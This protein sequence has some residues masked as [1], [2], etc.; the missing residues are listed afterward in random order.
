[1]LIFGK[2]F[3]FSA[4]F[5]FLFYLLIF[6]ALLENSYSHLDPDMGWHLKA[7]RHIARS[8]E[9]SRENLYNYTFSGEWINHEWLVDWISF[10]VYD[11]L[12]YLALSILFALVIVCLLV[13]VNISTRRLAN[14]PIAIAIIQLLG[15][16]ASLP[17]FGIR[18]Q[19]FSVLFLFL[20]LNIINAFR[21]EQ[22]W[23]QL[24]WLLPLFLIWVN[25]HG[26]FFF[27]LAIFV[28]WLIV[29][30]LGKSLMG[31]KKLG[32]Y[33]QVRNLTN[34][35]LFVAIIF[36]ALTFLIT[37]INPYGL[38]LY[39]F[40]IDYKN[41]AYLNLID[42]W[43]PL[44]SFP[45]GYLKIIYLGFLSGAWILYIYEVLREKK[46]RIDWW[47]LSLFILFLVLSFKSKR[48][49][50]LAFIATFPYFIKILAGLFD[51][52]KI[53]SM[54][55]GKKI[56]YLLF[57]C[58]LL[59]IV[60]LSVSI[61]FNKNP[62]NEFCSSYPCGAVK[63]LQSNKQYDDYRIFNEYGWGGY[64]IWVYPERQLFIDGRLPQVSFAGKTFIEEYKEFFIKEADRDGKLSEHDIRLVL[65]RA[66]D[67]PL[68]IKKW[69]KI[70]FRITDEDL[71][72]EN[73]LRKYLNES[74]DWEIIYQDEVAVIYKK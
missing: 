62:F 10:E 47:Q 6:V 63:F 59:S 37:L 49:F 9:V 54:V 65:L 44:Y 41:T 36:F 8:G 56:E 71:I 16:Y 58:L 73:H 7:G 69:E 51:W 18:M 22:K 39:S 45:I 55:Y 17:H 25:F 5:W 66:K 2:K 13:I 43:L 34:K 1:M 33:F 53:K 14:K 68:N 52:K 40:L 15:L 29:E 42:E 23:R 64:L 50:P 46:D 24:L 27:G 32:L 72:V 70:F 28:F 4:L 31:I 61:P 12:G 11:N 20:E 30:L 35:D 67:L 38:D 48:N 19:E 57:F 3:N 26:S 74:P 21:Q 60:S